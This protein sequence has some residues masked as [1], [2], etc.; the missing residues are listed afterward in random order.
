M[1]R[2]Y[3]DEHLSDAIAEQS[4]VRGV[5]ALIAKDAG[6]ANRAIPDDDQL[7]FAYASGRVLVT[8]DRDYV[9]LAYSRVP[10]AGVMFL[11]RELGIGD[12]VAY[13]EL[14]ANCYEPEEMQ[15]RLEFCDW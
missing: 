9:L 12:Y 11:Q 5:D 8:K 10:N 1:L 13:L 3:F 6:R 15:N 4:R 2:Y 7:A 14:A